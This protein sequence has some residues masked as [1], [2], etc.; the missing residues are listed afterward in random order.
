MKILQKI[1]LKM[2][3]KYEIYNNKYGGVSVKIDID[4]QEK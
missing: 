2:N 3:S 1:L 4:G